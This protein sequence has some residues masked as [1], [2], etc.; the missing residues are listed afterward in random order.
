MSIMLKNYWPAILWAFFILLICD[1]KMGGVSHS[2]AFFEGFDKLVHCGLFFTMTVLYSG[3]YLR[4]NQKTGLSVIIAVL[5]V[6]GM[7]A[8]G[9]AIE[10]LQKYFFTWRSADWNDLFADTV[11]ICMGMFSVLITSNA[12]KY[13]KK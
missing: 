13:A 4:H 7:I 11:G 1:V 2:P 5:I 6:L 9:G 3:S 10:L 12:V 8:F